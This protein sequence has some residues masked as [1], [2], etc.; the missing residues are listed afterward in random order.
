MIMYCA[1]SCR[2]CHL[3]DPKLRCARENLDMS[4][5]PAYKPGDMHAMFSSIVDRYGND[6]EVNILSTDP[7]AITIDNFVTDEEAETL[8]ALQSKWER[9]TDTGTM[10]E[11]GETGRVLSTGRTSANSWCTRDCAKH[12]VVSGLLN[13]LEDVVG[14]SRENYESFQVLRCKWM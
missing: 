2:A 6:Y 1:A 7:W 10:N 9:S 12:P 5:D 3:R 4:P 14:I 13:K 11:F 8:I